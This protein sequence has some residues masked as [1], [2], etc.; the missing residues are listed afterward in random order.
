MPISDISLFH[1]TYVSFLNDD[2]LQ[3]HYNVK[4]HKVVN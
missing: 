1:L 2:N 4:F 3:H